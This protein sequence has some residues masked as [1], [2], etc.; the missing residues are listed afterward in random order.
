MLAFF[1]KFGPNSDFKS[2]PHLWRG[3]ICGDPIEDQKLYGCITSGK[4]LQTK[5]LR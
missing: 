5:E 1:R 4:T 3:H 2:K